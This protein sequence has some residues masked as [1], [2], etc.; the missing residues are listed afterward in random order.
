MVDFRS[1][2]C[3]KVIVGGFAAVK[4]IDSFCTSAEVSC[5]PGTG[6]IDLISSRTTGYI[7]PSN[8]AGRSIST[9]R[10]RRQNGKVPRA[11][12]DFGFT[13]APRQI[14][15]ISYAKSISIYNIAFAIGDF[16]SFLCSC[17]RKDEGCDVVTRARLITAPVFKKRRQFSDFPVAGGSRR[18]RNRL[19][20]PILPIIDV[21]IIQGFILEE[22]GRC[23]LGNNSFVCSKG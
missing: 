8:P 2:G 20:A 1:Q 3:R 10:I 5:V 9:S 7:V 11:C 15:I 4:L 17:A 22:R 16:V 18:Y 13:P 19:R 21:V 23:L 12:L 14:V 6:F